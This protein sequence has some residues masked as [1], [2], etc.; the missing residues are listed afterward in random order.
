VF[1]VRCADVP[2]AVQVEQFETPFEFGRLKFRQHRRSLT[3]SDGRAPGLAK[4]ARFTSSH[5]PTAA[6]RISVRPNE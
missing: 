2:G 3:R 1:V 5:P 4:G 6:T